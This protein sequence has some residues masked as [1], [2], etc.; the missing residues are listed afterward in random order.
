MGH[1]F[2]PERHQ[3]SH[4]LLIKDMMYEVKSGSSVGFAV[5]KG[6]GQHNW[7]L[8]SRVN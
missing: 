6:Y 4:L 2:V 1:R 5:L 8:T 7:G 3:S